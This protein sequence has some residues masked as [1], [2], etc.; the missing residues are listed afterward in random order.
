MNLRQTEHGTHL[1]RRIHSAS[2]NAMPFSDCSVLPAELQRKDG[3]M[4]SQEAALAGKVVLLFFSAEWCPACTRFVPILNTLYE[5]SKENEQKLEVIYVSSDNDAAQKDHYMEKK[6]GDWLSVSF[7]DKAARDLLKTKYGCFAGKES[8]LF[9]GIKRR[10]GI[11]SI[12]I[13]SPTGDEL[14]HM[15]CDPPTEINRKGDAILDEWLQHQWP[16]P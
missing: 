12:V 8:S 14:V 11:P 5:D 4:V 9:P 6:H 15:D 10:A 7:D 13:I 16:T 3:T 2:A 1:P